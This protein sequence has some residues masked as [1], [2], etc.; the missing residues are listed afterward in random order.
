MLGVDG[1]TMYADRP[2]ICR[3]YPLKRLRGNNREVLLQYPQ[4]PA[5]TGVYGTQGTISDFLRVHDVD[6]LFAAKDRYFDMALRIAAV[7]AKAVKREPHRFATIRDIIGAH[8]EFRTG[9][10][11]S[12][13]DVDNVVSN[14]C[15]ERQIEFPATLDE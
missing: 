1:C 8:C 13:I 9:T 11:P 7:L 12:L 5:S 6:D 4:L 15:R 14:Y 3:T 10:I 2:Q